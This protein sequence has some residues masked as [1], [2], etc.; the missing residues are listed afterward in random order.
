MK[1]HE[2]KSA[3]PTT[4]K[5]SG[6]D[7]PKKYVGGWESYDEPQGIGAR[8]DKKVLA[9]EADVEESASFAPLDHFGPE[10]DMPLQNGPVEDREIKLSRRPPK[11]Q[12]IAS[13]KALSARG[14]P[15]RIN[16]RKVVETIRRPFAGTLSN[17]YEIVDDRDN[18]IGFAKVIDGVINN[19]EYDTDADQ[20]YRG[21]I[22]SAMLSQIVAEA[23]HNSANL[24]IQIVDM[25]EE[26][27]YLLGR[28]GF[29]SIGG[30][31]MKRGAGSIR[32]QSVHSPQGMVNREE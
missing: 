24:S 17:E 26:I 31:I 28:Y 16:P 30:N 23:D 21:Q 4:M 11:K 7:D 18:S 13:V 19:L 8:R 27:V 9:K 25:T 20:N 15:P 10:D 5:S 3:A 1:L 32:P 22:L 14:K 12:V 2:L 6:T 29:Q